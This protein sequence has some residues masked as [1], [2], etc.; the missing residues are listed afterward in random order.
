MG[1]PEEA[2]E[3]AEK[4]YSCEHRADEPADE[5]GRG[6]RAG[7]MEPGCDERLNAGGADGIQRLADRGD[8]ETGCGG[9]GHP[10]C[11]DPRTRGHADMTQAGTVRCREKNAAHRLWLLTR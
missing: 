7:D 9:D 11:G 8:S 1:C 3:P 4:R 5:P 2:G 6:A 10:A